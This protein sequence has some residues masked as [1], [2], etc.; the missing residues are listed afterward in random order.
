MKMCCLLCFE[1]FLIFLFAVLM[2]NNQMVTE[3]FRITQFSGP[4]LHLCLWH[5]SELHSLRALSK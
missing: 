4:S 1:L 5:L 2:N 3:D